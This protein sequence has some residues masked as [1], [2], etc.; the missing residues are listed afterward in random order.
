MFWCSSCSSPINDFYIY[1]LPK[2]TNINHV[3]EFGGITM[4]W[5]ISSKYRVILYPEENLKAEMH[6]IY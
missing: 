3:N 6:L 2:L 5:N 4:K 1:I